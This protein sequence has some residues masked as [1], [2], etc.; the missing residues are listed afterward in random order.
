MFIM[1]ISEGV[2]LG[3]GAP[4]ATTSHARGPHE[5]GRLGGVFSRRLV[6]S[7]RLCQHAVYDGPVARRS[8]PEPPLFLPGGRA[9]CQLGLKARA[10][11]S[12]GR[13]PLR[14]GP[15]QRQALCE[16]FGELRC[17]SVGGFM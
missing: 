17:V 13:G 14:T 1:A 15:H 10:R 12:A 4:D 3:F 7:G 2:P 11:G 8:P 16:A 6:V 9:R 5:C